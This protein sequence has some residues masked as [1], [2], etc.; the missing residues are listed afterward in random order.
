MEK[1]RPLVQ[2]DERTTL[3]T[4]MNDNET[5]HK[6]L[7]IQRVEC[8]EVFDE[9]KTLNIVELERIDNLEKEVKRLK[10]I[11]LA[12]I[13]ALQ[14]FLPKGLDSIIDLVQKVF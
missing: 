2:D 3:Y 13:F 12:A 1:R 7:E 9:L 8:Q 11:I 5:A 6:W 4:A 10:Y 14:A